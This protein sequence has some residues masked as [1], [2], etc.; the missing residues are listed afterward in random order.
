MIPDMTKAAWELKKAEITKD[1]PTIDRKQFRYNMKR[2]SFTKEWGPMYKA[3][4]FFTRIFAFFIRVLPKVGPLRGLAY[5]VPT[6]QTEKM[7]E[8]SF[9]AAVTRDR[10]AFA[11]I[12]ADDLRISNRD[13]DT[14]KLASPGEYQL[15]DT[16][17]DKLLKKLAAKQFEGVTPELRE[18]ILAFY[19]AMKTP[20]P[21]GTAAQL[22]ALKAVNSP[23]TPRAPSPPPAAASS[24]VPLP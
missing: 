16:T 15:T 20:D 10:Q 21:H 5:K 3:P 6:P 9:D 18:N 23:A 12:E 11:G 14:G 1:Q 13:L 7:F 22:A 19:A 8:D 17:Y 4:G 24:T 2:T